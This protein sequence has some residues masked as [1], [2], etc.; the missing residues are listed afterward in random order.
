MKVYLVSSGSDS[1]Y[2]II[3]VFSTLEKA[4]EYIAAI[5]ASTMSRYH[6]LND[7]I[8]EYELDCPPQDWFAVRVV[9]TK[10]GSASAY[11]VIEEGGELGRPHFTAMGELQLVNTVRTT[12][13]QQAIKVTNELRAR[14]LALN[15]WGDNEQLREL[16][17]RH[18]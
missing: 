4:K 13:R 16:L 15:A 12:D 5:N 17:A 2:A 1:D 7:E 6:E 11:N 9:I 14:L 10:D 3:A 18:P 8:E